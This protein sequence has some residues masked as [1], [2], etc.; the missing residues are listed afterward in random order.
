MKLFI[1]I[2]FKQ[3]NQIK[4]SN[5]KKNQILIEFNEL[6]LIKSNIDTIK[7]I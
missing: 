6:I 5:F 4:I 1:L 7:P 2:K 3:K